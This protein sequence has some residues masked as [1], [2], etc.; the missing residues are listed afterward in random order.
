MWLDRYL[1]AQP[2]SLFN[3]TVFKHY[4]KRL[5]C[6][7]ESKKEMHST[8]KKARITYTFINQSFCFMPGV[9]CTPDKVTIRMNLGNL[10]TH[11]KS[12]NHWKFSINEYTGNVASFG[13]VSI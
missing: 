1:P 11:P 9:L 10:G 12:A 4:Y 7:L 6:H 13:T 2:A 5:S 3:G 8:I